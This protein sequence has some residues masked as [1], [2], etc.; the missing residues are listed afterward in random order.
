MSRWAHGIPEVN[1]RMNSAATMAPAPRWLEML[2]RS[3]MS[4]LSPSRYSSCSGRR[5][6]R[7]PAALAAASTR[8]HS[9]SSLA[10][11]PETP[12]PSAI[13]TAPVRVAMSTISSG[14]MC[15]TA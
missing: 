14:L 6:I 8:A 12:W 4:L 10:I 7:S 13:T 5:H 9:P 2:L 15:S 3:A 1:S 11:T